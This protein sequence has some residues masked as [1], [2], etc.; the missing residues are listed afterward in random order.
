MCLGS[1]WFHQRQLLRYELP[2]L[3]LCLNRNTWRHQPIHQC[4]PRFASYQISFHPSPNLTE[5]D[6]RCTYNTY[7]NPRIVFTQ[8]SPVIFS[9]SFKAERGQA[10]PSL[11]QM[12]FSIQYKSRI[13]CIK[14]LKQVARDLCTRACLSL[15]KICLMMLFCN[16][17]SV[18]WTDPGKPCQFSNGCFKLRRL[19]LIG[20]TKI[21]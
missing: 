14:Y 3:D 6:W 8:C 17:V 16:C 9:L 4:F 15:K 1:R 5:E 20:H 12:M 21:R 10:R 19:I 13:V 18:S 11:N 7:I 2:E